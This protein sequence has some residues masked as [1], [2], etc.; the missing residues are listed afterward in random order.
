MRLIKSLRQR[1]ITGTF[2][3]TVDFIMR[4]GGW[5]IM[6]RC[7]KQTQ[8]TIY[9]CCVQ[10]TASQWFLGFW[11]DP[12]FREHYNLKHFM[13]KENFI[14]QG[15]AFK[16]LNNFP[17]G[18]IIS[19]LYISRSDFVNM[20][21]PPS[22]RAFFVARDPRDLVI[23]KYFGLK[24]S[25]ALSDPYIFTMREHLNSIPV[26]EGIL[27]LINLGETFEELEGWVHSRDEAV[28]IFLF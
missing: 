15:G 21:K 28:R 26:E 22:Y 25:H 18:R 1:G 2:N 17:W 16:K 6:N 4:R 27:E 13:P 19:P 23:S 12:L 8:Y 9:H 7:A 11:A 20:K 3:K 10:K 24:Y 14:K 5:G